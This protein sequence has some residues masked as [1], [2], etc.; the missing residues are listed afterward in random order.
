MR[1]RAVV[2]SGADE[3]DDGR[4]SGPLERRLT[5]LSMVRVA[6]G[7]LLAPLGPMLLFAATSGERSVALVAYGYAITLVSGLP[8]V[9]VYELLGLRKLWHYLV[10]G[11]VLPFVVGIG[12]LLTIAYEPGQTWERMLTRAAAL[13]ALCAIGAAVFWMVAVRPSARPLD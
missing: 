3:D 9:L 1:E 2:S 5:R 4:R 6:R 7:L 10:G 12:L 8:V 11:F 13:G